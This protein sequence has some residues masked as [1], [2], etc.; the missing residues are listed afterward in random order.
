MTLGTMTTAKRFH[1]VPPRTWELI[2]FLLLGRTSPVRHPARPGMG[3]VLR[4]R[5]GE[6]PDTKACTAS[7]SPAITPERQPLV[8]RVRNP[9]G[10]A[11]PAGRNPPV[12]S[13]RHCRRPARWG[14]NGAAAPDWQPGWRYWTERGR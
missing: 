3:E 2:F 13:R 8:T 10:Q 11:L 12:R 6:R 9:I 5:K 7:A 4:P 14:P 1:L